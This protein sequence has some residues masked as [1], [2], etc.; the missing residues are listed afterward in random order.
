V[1]T[2][3]VSYTKA[4]ERRLLRFALWQAWG[5]KCYWCDAPKSYLEVEI[6]HIVPKGLSQ[7]DLKDAL[8]HYGLQAD[9]DLHHPRNL[10]PICDSCNGPGR[11]GSHSYGGAAVVLDHLRKAAEHRGAVVR[12]V[13]NFRKGGDVAKALLELASSDTDA[14]EVR[15]LFSEYFPAVASTAATIDPRLLDRPTYRELNIDCGFPVRVDL[16]HRFT[17]ELW[18][19]EIVLDCDLETALEGPLADLLRQLATEMEGKLQRQSEF[20]P[21][22]VGPRVP[23]AFDV[24]V[25]QIEFPRKEMSSEFEVEVICTFDGGLTSSASR[26]SDD[27]GER[28]EL[29]GEAVVSGTALINGTWLHDEGVEFSEDVVVEHLTIEAWLE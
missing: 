17:R 19:L 14:T 4:G 5:M 15:A 12:T 1:V 18:L 9:F 26:Y 3:D 20:E 21:V 27:G 16:D 29:Q 28:L 13:V 11:K 25:T 6:D 8:T 22:D 7:D 2:A 10:A 23:Y 24:R